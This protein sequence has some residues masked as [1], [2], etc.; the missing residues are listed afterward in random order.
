MLALVFDGKVRLRSDYPAPKVAR[1]EALVGVRVA[2]VCSTDLEVTKGYMGFS[3][4]MGHEF[5]GQVIEG[6][7][8]WKQKRVVAE[9]NCV[10]GR[11]DMCRSGLS[12]HCR[13]RTVI[14]I[15]G[16][17]GVFAEQVAIPAANLHEVPPAVSD[18]Q[19][20]FAE[21]LAAA[22]Q[23]TRQVKF[24]Q[25]DAVVVLGD[26]RLGQLVARVLRSLVRR[27]MLVGKHA[28]KLEMAEKQGIQTAAVEEFVPRA[29]ADV[30]VEATGSPRG[31]ELAL[32]TVRPRGVIV[33]KST[34]A[35]S[36]GLN[37]SPAVVAEVTVIGSR[38]GPLEVALGAL[39]SG[40][41]DVSALVSRRYPLAR[42][43]EALR[44]AG[45]PENV[46]V[47]IDVQ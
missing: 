37:L 14:G 29:D 2:G 35:T 18:E 47:L 11:C 9:I 5:V 36:E 23:V 13:D 25:S 39:A 28:A 34:F 41:V 46:K 30:V 16:R 38:C 3:G 4:V 1:G 26:G 24:Q 42:A 17:D 6:P 33:L 10:C 27:L 40:E 15:A 44:A 21:P 19:A 22:Y 32:R 43:A 8:A 12:N 45:E 20:V 31:L 7:S